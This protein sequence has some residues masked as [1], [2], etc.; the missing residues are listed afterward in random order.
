MRLGHELTASSKVIQKVKGWKEDPARHCC[1]KSTQTA[2]KRL[3][4]LIYKKKEKGN[5]EK[6]GITEHFYGISR[7]RPLSSSL[8]LGDTME[9]GVSPISP[10]VS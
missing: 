7:T 5:L 4:M 3:G 9:M 10:K 1:V 2:G 8:G 6:F